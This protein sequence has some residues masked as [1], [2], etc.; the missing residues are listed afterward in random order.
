M[1]SLAF[2]PQDTREKTEFQKENRYYEST[3]KRRRKTRRRK[4]R[5]KRM[6]GK[7]KKK[8]IKWRRRGMKRKM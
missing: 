4:R 3:R 1:L 5:M 7:R 6:S 8:W 2:P